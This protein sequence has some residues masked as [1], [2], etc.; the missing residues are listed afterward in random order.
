[1]ERNIKSLIDYR[2]EGTDGVIG[3]VEEF[4]FDDNTWD[5]RYIIAE[6]G[7]WLSGRKVL[8][9]PSALVKTSWQNGRFPVNL[10]KEQIKNSPDIC[11]INIYSL[12]TLI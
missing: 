3:N 10:T 11:G 2:L 8:I 1:M 12:W 5:I 7:S 6:T 9:A 4:Y